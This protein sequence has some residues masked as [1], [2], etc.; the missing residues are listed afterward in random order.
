MS[1]AARITE[2]ADLP[3]T[4]S[5]VRAAIPPIVAAA[6]VAL[7]LV[8]LRSHAVTNTEVTAGTAEP[9]PYS[10]MESRVPPSPQDE[11]PQPQ[12]F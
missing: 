2:S 7:V 5:L 4:A 6:A 8:A 3:S 12:A 11:E 10:A 1:D 9:T